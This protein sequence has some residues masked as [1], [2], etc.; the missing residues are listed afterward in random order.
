M[1]T[2]SDDI[3][4]VIPRGG[5]NLIRF[6]H[7]H[8]RIPTVQHFKGVCHIFVDA[9]ADPD[10]AAE[11]VATAKTSNPATCNTVE[12]VLVHAEA[13]AAFVPSAGWSVAPRSASRCGAT[14][15]FRAHAGAP[16]GRGAGDE[17][18]GCEYLD[19]ILAARVVRSI[20]E[21]IE[22]IARHGSDHTEAIL[23]R[24]DAITRSGSGAR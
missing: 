24:D 23:T 2:L 1:L 15:A 4:L 13:A 9:S 14:S 12:C 22:H 5:E 18:W 7:E 21:A 6:V 8:S 20:D 3:D 11:I 17:D 19:L 16:R 10:E